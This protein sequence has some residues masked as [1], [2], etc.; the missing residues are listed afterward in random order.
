MLYFTKVNEN[1]GFYIDSEEPYFRFKIEMNHQGTMRTL[2][3]PEDFA[4]FPQ[5]LTG[6]ARITKLFPKATPYSSVIELHAEKAGQIANNIIRQSYQ[7]K[8]EIL[9]STNNETSIMITKMPPSNVDTKIEDFE[10]TDLQTFMKT[11]KGFLDTCLEIK[12][13]TEEG[14]IA[15]FAK[16]EYN[17]LG[18]KQVQF[19]CPCSQDRMIT[20]LLTLSH[21]DLNEVFHESQFVEIRCDYCN[22][23]YHITKEE[24][25]NKIQ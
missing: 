24:M 15:H 20:N 12:D 9:V 25:T 1:L 19:N 14:I 13:K 6:R 5:T 22:K 4:Q 21:N 8:S 16:F 7:T 3:L 10:D 2:L 23:L 17:L 11:N 18:S